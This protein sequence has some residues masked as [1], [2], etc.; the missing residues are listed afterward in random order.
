MK[1]AGCWKQSASRWMTMVS[2]KNSRCTAMLLYLF[3]WG[4][5][6]E[7]GRVLREQKTGLCVTVSN[8][9]AKRMWLLLVS[10]CCFHLPV[11][12][13]FSAFAQRWMTADQY[14]LFP[15]LP[16]RFSSSLDTMLYLH[17]SQLHPLTFHLAIHHL[18]MKQRNKTFVTKATMHREILTA[19]VQKY[20]SYLKK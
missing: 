6:N 12:M 19:Y 17:P 1:A 14:V 20:Y 5:W 11:W 4:G 2:P 16:P 15:G 10:A 3:Q 9:R 18:C 13:R 8:E 7:Q